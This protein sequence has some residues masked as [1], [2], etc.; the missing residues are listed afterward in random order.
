MR[1]VRAAGGRDVRVEDPHL[2]SN[3]RCNRGSHRIQPRKYLPPPSITISSIRLLDPSKPV[4]FL[5][6]LS[7][8]IC[9]CFCVQ[10]HASVSAPHIQR[11][12]PQFPKRYHHTRRCAAVKTRY[13]QKYN[14]TPRDTIASQTFAAKPRTTSRRNW[15]STGWGK[16]CR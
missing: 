13:H 10:S 9:V 8:C 16:S 4:L 11:E 12:A 7:P 5:T 14:S 2:L 1:E 6:D 3:N 15:T